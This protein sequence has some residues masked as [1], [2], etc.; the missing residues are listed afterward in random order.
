MHLI[1]YWYLFPQFYCAAKI[2]MG[3][4]WNTSAMGWR[5]YVISCPGGKALCHPICCSK[6]QASEIPLN[7]RAVVEKNLL[8]YL[9]F[10]LAWWNIPL[11][12]CI[13]ELLL[14][15]R[16]KSNLRL[17]KCIQHDI[18]LKLLINNNN[19]TLHLYNPFQQELS[20]KAFLTSNLSIVTL[21]E[22]ETSVMLSTPLPHTTWQ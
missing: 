6:F 7:G 8:F 19:T 18:W 5:L 2:L 9:R 22:L 16:P 20:Q 13:T 4:K 10:C 11:S 21:S 12:V 15:Y 3:S 14:S 17:M 1:K